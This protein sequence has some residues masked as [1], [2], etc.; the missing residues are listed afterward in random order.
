MIT[1]NSTKNYYCL[2]SGRLLMMG[3]EKPNKYKT[4]KLG[5]I[6]DKVDIDPKAKRKVIVCFDFLAGLGRVGELPPDSNLRH[7]T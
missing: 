1:S 7:Q 3:N 2:S 4:L 6:T 5:K